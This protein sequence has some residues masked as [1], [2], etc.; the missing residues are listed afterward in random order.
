MSPTP[1]LRPPGI[2]SSYS[3]S[4][5][6]GR[7]TWHRV[8]ARVNLRSAFESWLLLLLLRLV[9]LL[10]LLLLLLVLLLL[11]LLLLLSCELKY[12]HLDSCESITGKMA[13]NYIILPLQSYKWSYT[14][15]PYKLAEN[16]WVSLFLFS[17][18]YK[19][20]PGVPIV[21]ITTRAS[22]T[23]GHHFFHAFPFGRNIQLHL[24]VVDPMLSMIICGD[25]WIPKG[26][27]FTN[28]GPAQAWD[29]WNTPTL[30]GSNESKIPP[31][32]PMKVENHLPSYL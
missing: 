9:F 5:P 30:L 26:T 13:P 2:S 4:S 32:G 12:Q 24:D 31:V 14:G 22:P 15:T 23:S 19:S 7:R 16:K 17:P 27:I 1:I 18:D 29:T 3:L 8:T 11:L 10:L 21:I 6:S 28:A 25:L 20:S